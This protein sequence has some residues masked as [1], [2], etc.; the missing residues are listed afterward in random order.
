MTDDMMTLRALLEKSSDADLLRETIGFAAERLMAL[1]VEG[2]TGAAGTPSAVGRNARSTGFGEPGAGGP[3]WRNPPSPPQQH[4]SPFS[5]IAV[6]SDRRDKQEYGFSSRS[7]RHGSALHGPACHT[8]RRPFASW[9]AP[10]ASP[11]HV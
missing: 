9:K 11:S 10:A 6:V 8:L 2:L 4:S 1:E 5:R 3:P 7:T